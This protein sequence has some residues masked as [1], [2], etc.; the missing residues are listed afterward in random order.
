MFLGEG[1][2][3]PMVVGCGVILLGTGLTTGVL[4]LP[5]RA[6]VGA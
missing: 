1:V 6:A 3:L 5:Q 2:T 4:K